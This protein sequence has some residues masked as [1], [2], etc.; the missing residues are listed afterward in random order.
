[1][2]DASEPLYWVVCLAAAVLGGGWFAFRWLHIARLIED[3]PTSRVRSAAQGYVELEGRAGLLSG[4]RNVAPLTQRDCAWWRYRVQHRDDSGKGRRERWCTV[5]SGRSGQPFLVDDGTGSCIVQPEGAVVLA[6][7]STTWY[8]ATPW[9]RDFP[10]TP[11]R[12][13][14][15]TDYRY[16]EERIHEHEL[17]YALGQFRTVSGTDTA[18]AD[19]A[20]RALLAEWKR[21]AESLARRFDR[22][23]DGTVSLEEWEQARL[24][25]R[26]SVEQQRE[27]RPAVAARHLLGPPGGGRLY[28]LA[29][30]R[31][32][33]V[34]R[35]F[36]RRA[37]LAFAGFLAAVYALGWL[38]QGLLPH[39]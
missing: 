21:D 1:M 31:A 14:A 4:T 23:G 18:D 30:F 10:G 38:V 27:E 37:L 6:A 29:T 12:R 19:E 17:V 28:L 33:D 3:T 13:G 9:P 32:A 5:A 16:F 34:A 7:E 26:R 22:D 20:L 25:A 39:A 24:E 36:R 8:G 11:N 35:R 15:G 2:A